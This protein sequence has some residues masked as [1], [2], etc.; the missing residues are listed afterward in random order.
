MDYIEILPYG[1]KNYSNDKQNEVI[2]KLYKTYIVPTKIKNKISEEL[3]IMRI[4]KF[5]KVPVVRKK[6][7]T[8]SEES[9]EN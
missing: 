8:S 4:Q 7:K 5:L 6:K 9:S 3:L 1:F 2:D